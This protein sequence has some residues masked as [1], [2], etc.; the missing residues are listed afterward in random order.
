MDSL[1]TEVESC[2][3]TADEKDALLISLQCQFAYLV[4][5]NMYLRELNN[6][7][8]TELN[9]CMKVLEENKYLHHQIRE[10][11]IFSHFLS[12]DLEFNYNLLQQLTPEHKQL[13]S[14]YQHS[15]SHKQHYRNRRS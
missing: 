6:I 13:N 10:V 12:K 14:Q 11:D 15:R 3:Q 4:K 2:S 7:L 5:K 8:V 1:I 9:K